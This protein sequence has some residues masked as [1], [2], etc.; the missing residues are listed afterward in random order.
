QHAALSFPYLYF[1]HFFCALLSLILQ[2][3]TR[4][5]FI[6]PISNQLATCLRYPFPISFNL[7]Q[8]NLFLNQIIFKKIMS[9]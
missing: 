2:L 6:L 9:F 8:Y 3:A 7:Q 4:L 1:L 5:R